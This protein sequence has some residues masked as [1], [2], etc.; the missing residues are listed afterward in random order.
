M[1]RH[2]GKMAFV[3]FL[4]IVPSM[5]ISSDKPHD[6]SQRQLRRRGRPARTETGQAALREQIISATAAVYAETGC[7][8]LSVEAVLQHAGL[9]RP[10]FYRHFANVEAPLRLLVARAHQDL[11]DRYC[12]RI[13]AGAGLE[14][15]MS[16]AVE[17]Y[18]AWCEAQGGLL[19]PFFIE[20][21]DPSS[22]V[23]ALRPQVLARIADIYTKTLQAEG[24]KVQNPLMVELMVTGIECLGY[25]FQLE[26]LTGDITVAM[27]KDAM[28]CLMRCTIGAAVPGPTGGA[29]H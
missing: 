5:L 29:A 6:S 13:P 21:H 12:D 1:I 14:E 22:P 2:F 3:A 4:P 25:R 23:S 19:R 24:L 17:M 8:G 28:L 20:L 16:T 27:I 7:H 18:L 9:S 10:T 26:R 15:K 11:L